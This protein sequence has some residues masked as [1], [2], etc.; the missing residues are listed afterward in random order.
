VILHY[1]LNSRIV[2]GACCYV[3]VMVL[4]VAAFK[5]I[6][7]N[8]DS[9]IASGPAIVAAYPTAILNGG[10]ETGTFTNWTQSGFS[11][12]GV[13]TGSKYAHAGTYGAALETAATQGFLSQKLTTTPGAAYLISFWLDSPAATKP[14]DFQVSWNGNV[15]LDKTNLTAIGWTNIQ[16][17]VTAMASISTLQF[18]YLNGSF[19]FGLDDVSVLPVAQLGIT[20]ISLAGANLM[21][22]GAGGLSNRTYYVLMGTNLTEPFNQWTPV[23]TN[24]PGV[25]GNF[26][27]TA[28]NA[29]NPNVSQRF[30]ILQ[31][32]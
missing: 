18:A 31:L 2:L 30:Y 4:F 27:I 16:L 32:Q 22:N 25:D 15:L 3:P 10:F 12:S 24:V 9:V 21:F 6:N 7:N 29:V 17:T 14:N 1:V 20:G 28:T 26:S 19:Y 13:T 11:Y 23:A 8:G 5:D